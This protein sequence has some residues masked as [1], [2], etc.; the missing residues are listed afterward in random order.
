MPQH[1]PSC[2]LA[3]VAAWAL[4]TLGVALSGC[5][6]ETS[7]IED[8]VGATAGGDGG[9]L[10]LADA[11]TST[12]GVELLVDGVQPPIGPP[13]GGT[14]AVVRAIGM[15]TGTRITFGGA[16][17]KVLKVV[18]PSRAVVQVPSGAPGQVDVRV[19]LQSG[20]SGTLAKGF[21]YVAA[22]SAA[23]TLA[24]ILPP[25]ALSSGGTP[26]VIEGG[27]LGQGALLFIGWIPVHNEWVDA[28]TLNALSR[29][30][31]RAPWMWPS[32]T[33][34][35]SRRCWRLRCR[36]ATRRALRPRWSA[37]ARRQAPRPAA[38]P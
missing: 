7:T 28:T 14:Y 19:E 18:D 13:G 11:A 1:L 5:G 35:A 20:A 29:P 31:R 10:H 9:S 36:L 34:M 3:S 17:A 4:C 32:P 21:S 24:K 6:E 12:G 38:R 26:L 27:A 33:P 8:G 23:P 16:E 25:K 22:S 2:R 15:G 37:A 30:C